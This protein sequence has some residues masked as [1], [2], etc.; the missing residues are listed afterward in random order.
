MVNAKRYKAYGAL[1]GVFLLGGVAGG[2]SAWALSQRELR[3]VLS[4]DRAFESRRLA[5]LSR[6]LGLSDSQRERIDAI[7]RKHHDERRE[8]TRDVFERCG[9]PLRAHRSKLH[10][11]IREVL[12]QEQRERYDALVREH[13]QRFFEK[14]RR[15]H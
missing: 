10:A 11:E 2:A 7:F 1:A 9:E 3:S 6:E 14:R 4:A 8:L 15:R 12:T 5:A 13:D